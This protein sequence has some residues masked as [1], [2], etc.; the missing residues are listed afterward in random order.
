MNN[1]A[2]TNEDNINDD[3]TIVEIPLNKKYIKSKDKNV[4][5]NIKEYEINNLNLNL[6]CNKKASSFCLNPKLKFNIPYEKN[7]D[8]NSNEEDIN[9]SDDDGIINIVNNFRDN[10]KD[11][12]N[13]ENI[14]I[15]NNNIINNDSNSKS[16]RSTITNHS[17]HSYSVV[18]SVESF[19]TVHK[20]NIFSNAHK[21]YFS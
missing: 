3:D 6:K 17:V 19:P 11:V 4:N 8:K 18:D 7:I 20:N 2:G 12:N 13:K 1:N 21:K 5:K 9:D 10:F 16:N 15:L 14:N